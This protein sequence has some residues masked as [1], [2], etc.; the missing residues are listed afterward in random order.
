MKAVRKLTNM[1]TDV[2]QIAKLLQKKAP[3]G[4]KLSLY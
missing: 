2:R 1:G 3:P 4:H